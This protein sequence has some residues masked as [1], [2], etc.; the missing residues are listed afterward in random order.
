MTRWRNSSAPPATRN[1]RH[2]RCG[3]AVRDL[4][5]R[6]FACHVWRMNDISDEIIVREAIGPAIP[7]LP[8]ICAIVIGSLALLMVG[9]MPAL[10]GSLTDEGRLSASGIG[11][12]ATF[13]SLAMGLT[14][15]IA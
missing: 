6:P 12:C 14:A 10:L 7:L 9:V 15:G 5:G 2:G 8:A 4:R 1:N 11:L 13:E 3:R